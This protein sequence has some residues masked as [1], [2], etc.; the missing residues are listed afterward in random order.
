MS[1]NLDW[2]QIIPDC[3][4]PTNNALRISVGDADVAFGG[5]VDAAKVFGVVYDPATHALKCVAPVA[6]V[7]QGTVLDATQV[8]KSILNKTKGQ[9]RTSE[10]GP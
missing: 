10:P 4:D 7:E 8:L 2:T 3:Y 1:T 5:L 6:A 9:L